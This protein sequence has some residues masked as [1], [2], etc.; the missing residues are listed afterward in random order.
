MDLAE[1]AEVDLQVG[2]LEVVE[3]DLAAEDRGERA[4]EA[5]AGGQG[6]AGARSGH[7][8][9]RAKSGGK[10]GEKTGQSTDGNSRWNVQGMAPT[11]GETARGF[12]ES[13]ARFCPE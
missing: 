6:L 4:T 13:L 9:G 12:G 3:L 1:D 7:C 5:L 10:C 11:R 2:R 8:S